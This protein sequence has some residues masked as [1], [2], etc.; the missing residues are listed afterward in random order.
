[1]KRLLFVQFL[2]LSLNL[3]ATPIDR[4]TAQ[5]RAEQVLGRAV[6]AV[7]SETLRRAP[8]QGLQT[9][10]AYYV[11]NAADGQ[12]FAII[13]ADDAF[14]TVLGYSTT[15]AFPIDK[16][17]PCALQLYLNTFSKAAE[18]GARQEIAAEHVVAA[19]GNQQQL[20]LTEWGQGVPYNTLCPKKDGQL[21]PSGCVATAL[22][23]LLYYWRWPVQ[24]KG[25]SWAK[26]GNGETYSGTLEHTYDWT[27]M[28]PTT[29][30][31]KASE[32]AAQAVAQLMY[33]CG[34]SVNMDFDS[35]GSR[36]QT[37]IKAL[38]EHFS[39]I[40]STMRMYHAEC[41][42]TAEWFDMLRHEINQN[43]P[44]YYSATSLTNGGKDAVGHAFIVDGYDAYGKVHVNWGWDGDFNGYF[45]LSKMNPGGY[46]FTI[47]QAALLGLEPAR[48]GETGTSVE[49]L[50]VRDP[51]SC[52][53]TGTIQTSVTFDVSVSNVW[54]LNG[55]T[56]SWQLSLGL[57][58]VTN[59]MLGEVKTGRVPGLSLDPGH[60]Y[61][62]EF[63]VIGCSLKGSYPNG[64]YAIRLVFRENGTREWLLPDMAGGL[65]KNAV[66]VKINGTRVTFTDGSEYIATAIRNINSGSQD[67]NDGLTRV[68]DAAGRL[69]YAAPTARFN[70]WDVPA[71]GILVIK[72]GD[73]VRK[74]VR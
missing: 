32:A 21:C 27:A 1:M 71:R 63:A 40:P 69:V 65:K 42:T 35:D 5:Q 36:A 72:Q 73:A 20:C 23:Q 45:D 18:I 31:N 7:S 25:Y 52:T 10:D 50:L 58:D 13:A 55:S 59:T 48:N 33:D 6:K 8:K 66:Y 67:N 16:S 70:L 37:P 17:M 24:G 61:K 26:D 60:G 57:F 34:L 47:N 3:H 54:N 22:A 30:E 4:A 19:T 46:Q 39:Y 51:L 62:G 56:H 43:R 38:C 28:L 44:I 53:Q 11:F 12:G 14:G 64:D 49:Y 41:Y 9:A 15:Q 68:F 74:V 29:A 2:I